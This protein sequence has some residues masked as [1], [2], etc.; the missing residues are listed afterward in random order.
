MLLAQNRKPLASIFLSANE[1]ADKESTALYAAKELR[2]YL[3]RMTSASFAIEEN[4]ADVPA[5]P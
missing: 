4:T 1:I 3:D 5:Q 2:Y